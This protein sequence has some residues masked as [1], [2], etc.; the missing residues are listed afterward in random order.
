M[1]TLG[2]V[3]AGGLTAGKYDAGIDIT[4]APG[5]HTY[6]K[7][8]GEAGVPPVFS[9]NGSENVKTAEVLYPV[10]KRITEEGLDAFGYTNQVVFP[11][12][13]TP[14]D[15]AKPAKLHADVSYAVCNRIC[16]PGHNQA[17]LTLQPHGAGTS[18]G[19]V[20]LALAQVPHPVAD[21]PALAITRV[22]NAKDPT[23][24]LT[25]TGHTPLADIFPDAPEGY[26][27]STKKA[28]AETWTLT[29]A[30]SVG[31]SK[32]TPVPVTLVLAEATG[33]VRTTATF[34]IGPAGK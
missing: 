11:V 14:I 34:D 10:P 16:V 32:T 12:A 19:L 6:W 9:F 21:V 13:V 31:T 8:P 1:A 3:A 7:M 27:F 33:A 4:M 22:A 24:T 18:P 20:Q 30:Q 28:G 23:W 15:A 29:A 5:S 25:W 17:D 26:Y 2:L